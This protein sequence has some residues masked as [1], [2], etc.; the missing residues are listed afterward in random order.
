MT[1]LT[2]SREIFALIL[3]AIALI[4][5]STAQ[6]SVVSRPGCN[7]TDDSECTELEWNAA[8]SQSSN[9]LDPND[10]SRGIDESN[11]ESCSE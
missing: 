5:I 1:R 3:I 4:A 9:D 7:S 11:Q 2:M 8:N 6:S 10:C